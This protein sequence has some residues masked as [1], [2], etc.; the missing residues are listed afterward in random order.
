MYRLGFLI[1]DLAS[2]ANV[3]VI[4]IRSGRTMLQKLSVTLILE[5]F[6]F[7]LKYAEKQSNIIQRRVTERS[8]SNISE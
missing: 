4:E 5:L 1:V 2:L 7:N 8:S 6:H 3:I